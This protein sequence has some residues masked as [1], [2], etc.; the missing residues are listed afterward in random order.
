MSTHI[1][2]LRQH[3]HQANRASD[4]RGYADTAT[5]NLPKAD[6]EKVIRA[7]R[8]GG[9]GEIRTHGRGSESVSCGLPVAVTAIFASTAVAHCPKLLKNLRGVA[10]GQQTARFH[11]PQKRNDDPINFRKLPTTRATAASVAS[12]IA[13][14]WL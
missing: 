1:F 9:E 14:S 4:R 8:N 3:N 10:D 7:E 11:P 6:A 2:S 5:N 12:V 13:R